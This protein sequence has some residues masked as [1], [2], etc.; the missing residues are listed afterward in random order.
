MKIKKF[1][2]NKE[3]YLTLE[4]INDIFLPII[5]DGSEDSDLDF[6]YI[7]LEISPGIFDRRDGIHTINS[8]KI[9]NDKKVSKLKVLIDYSFVRDI[10]NESNWVT[11]NTTI[12]QY[13]KF[14]EK[15]KNSLKFIEEELNRY[16]YILGIES[17]F[18]E[19]YVMILNIK[20]R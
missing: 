1:N 9:T 8:R 10:D 14:N 17:L 19:T 20:K 11:D 3:E 4:Q 18:G 6:T 15:Y 7:H 5:D 2:E 12:D 13:I 16:N